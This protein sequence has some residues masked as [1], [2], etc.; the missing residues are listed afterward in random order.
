VTRERPPQVHPNPEVGRGVPGSGNDAQREQPS[1]GRSRGERE[2][3]AGGSSPV[4]REQPTG[5]TSRVEREPSPDGSDVER[6]QPERNPR[7]ARQSAVDREL[8]ATA[9]TGGPQVY[10]LP[11]A[12]SEWDTAKSRA[13]VTDAVDPGR[14]MDDLDNVDALGRQADRET[15]QQ[16]RGRGAPA[17]DLGRDRTVAGETLPLQRTGAADAKGHRYPDRDP[18]LGRS[19]PPGPGSKSGR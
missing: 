17:D 11:N 13:Q 2:Q 7:N 6:E 16:R 14:A 10:A 3:P 19:V 1:A 9:S 15:L 12:P 5:G 8:A 18:G 4:E